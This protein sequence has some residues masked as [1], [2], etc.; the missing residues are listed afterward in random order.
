[1]GLISTVAEAESL[2]LRAGESGK[3]EKNSCEFGNILKNSAKNMAMDAIF[4]QAGKTFGLS[5]DLLRAV[6][7]TESNFN[8]NAVSKA[9]A[10]G[11]MQLMP[12][13][14]KSLG[15]ADPY[16]PWQNIMG[17]AKY[18][19][20][21][22]DRFKDVK[23]A[24]AAYNAGP[25]S[26]QKYGGIPPYEETQNYVKKVMGYIGETLTAD[27]DV[28]SPYNGIDGNGMAYNGSSLAGSAV[29]RGWGG[30]SLINTPGVFE[31]LSFRQQG[32]EIVMDKES[33]TSLI[34][35]LRIQMMMNA[36][37]EIGVMEI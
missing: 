11:V 20:E 8:P 27:R 2:R 3:R 19:K 30:N 12:G 6:A 37:R 7:K 29:Y 4:E 9:G 22:L 15:V 28:S 23:L 18:L 26:V 34:Q 36:G 35:I 24:L 16:D 5:P 17:G 1:M 25:G 21:N 10:M 33:F 14:A 31:N 13:T 32:D